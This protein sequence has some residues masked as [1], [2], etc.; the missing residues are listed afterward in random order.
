MALVK[1]KECGQSV[2][3]EA[4]ACPHCGITSPGLKTG[5]LCIH[6][7]AAVEGKLYEIRVVVDGHL[8]AALAE[9]Q[10]VTLELPPGRHVLKVTCGIFLWKTVA[11]DIEA[12]KTLSFRTYPSMWG[13]LG[14]GL[15]LER[16]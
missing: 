15:R 8:E 2:S 6:R 10:S 11:V 14:G 13:W 1:C 16:A 7:I 12:G 3:T 4:D 5:R 9:D